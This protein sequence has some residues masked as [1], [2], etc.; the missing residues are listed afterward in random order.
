MITPGSLLSF[1][2]QNIVQHY[3]CFYHRTIMLQKT[4]TLFVLAVDNKMSEFIG[5]WFLVF[6]GNEIGWI[7]ESVCKHLTLNRE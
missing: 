7:S 1:S 5:T 2:T 6:S 4:D 3:I